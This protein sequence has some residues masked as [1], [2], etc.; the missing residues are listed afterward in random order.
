MAATNDYQAYKSQLNSP[1]RYHFEVTPNDSTDLTH[2]TRG[3]YVGVTGDV[4][5]TNVNGQ[6][7][8]YTNLAAG[9][10]HPMCV[11]RVWSTGTTATGIIAVY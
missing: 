1:P 5:I 8:T 4:K 11:S 2:V 9:V 10:H 3:I 7:V 6:T